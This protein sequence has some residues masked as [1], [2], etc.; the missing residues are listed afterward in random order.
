MLVLNI[1][2]KIVSYL[3]MNNEFEILNW[4]S[5]FFHKKIASVILRKS[6]DNFLK[7][8][9]FECEE[10]GVELIYLFIEEGVSISFSLLNGYNHILVDNKVIYKTKSITDNDLDYHIS[11]YN[12][13]SELLY[14]LAMQAGAKS[15]YRID[16]NFTKGD[17]ERLYRTWINNSVNH[18]IADK[19]LVYRKQNKIIG[20][21]TLKIDKEESKIG[22]IASDPEYRKKG[23]GTALVRACKYYAYNAKS[24]SLSVATQKENDRACS[25]YMKNQFEKFMETT[26]IHVWINPD[27]CK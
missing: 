13:P 16:K 22:L 4:D 3:N 12:G 20:F 17:F 11:E 27:N 18:T 23:I 21:I 25:F 26:V 8:T 7:R 19:V 5:E 24:Q 14:N 2:S 15:R 6:D 9:L 10:I 1:E